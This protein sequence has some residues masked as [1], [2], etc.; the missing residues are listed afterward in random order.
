[1]I[2]Y[3][4]LRL[5]VAKGLKDYLGCPVIKSNQTAEAPPY[6]YVSYTFTT[7]M[8]ENKG[9]YGEYEDGNARK[10]VNSIISV[11]AQSD[12]S[13]ES[14]TLANK[15]REWLDYAGTVYLNDNGVIVQSVGTVTNRDNVLT[16]GYEYK[17]GFDAVFWLFDTIE[18]PAPQVIEAVSFNQVEIQNETA[19]DL[20][21]LLEDRLDGVEE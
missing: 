10:P 9:T 11:T 12:D 21:D 7:L 2:D 20:N 17:N 16:V 13:I 4:N 1:M 15:A 8:T 6:P 18:K 5:T 3:E 14:V 19:D